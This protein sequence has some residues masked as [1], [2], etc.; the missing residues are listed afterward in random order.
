MCVCVCI[1][2]YSCACMCVCACARA[3]VQNVCGDANQVPAAC[4]ALEKAV[5]FHLKNSSFFGNVWHT[6]SC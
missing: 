5:I 1:Y 4:V 2:F 3:Y 6:Y